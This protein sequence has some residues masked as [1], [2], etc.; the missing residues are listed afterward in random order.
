MNMTRTAADLTM[1]RLIAAGERG[2]AAAFIATLSPDVIVRSPITQ[3]IRFEGIEQAT[4]LFEQVF[5]VISGIR[6]YERL[7]HGTQTQA[8]FWR[9]RVGKHYLEEA[10]L[11]RLDE[12]GR[13]AEMT[14][15]MRPVPGVMELA[16]RLAPRL[17][18]E[19]S[20]LRAVPVRVMLRFITT[21]YRSNEP[22]VLSLTG[23][24][25]AVPSMTGEE[26]S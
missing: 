6:I 24:G 5:T 23:A 21:L 11:L 3:R 16:A 1:E 7:G 26:P 2:D 25:V 4:A 8:I 10:N 13:V 22:L 9:G 20:R 17:A 14:V 18:A 12:M 15:F 19:R